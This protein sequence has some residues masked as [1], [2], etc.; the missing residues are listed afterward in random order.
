MG[1]TL[2]SDTSGSSES[3]YELLSVI[4]GCVQ[5]SI[6]A[7][8]HSFV[9]ISL[10]YL[11][12]SFLSSQFAQIFAVIQ[13]RGSSLTRDLLGVLSWISDTF[14]YQGTRSSSTSSQYAS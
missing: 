13:A 2:L 7:C 3:T 5:V 1:L 11:H 10:L 14:S 6:R 8:S 12:C 4:E 9:I